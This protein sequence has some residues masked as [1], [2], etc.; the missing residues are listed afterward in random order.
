MP[1]SH[2]YRRRILDDELDVLMNGLPA[3]ALEGAKAVGKTATASERATTVHQLDDPDQRALA[4]ADPGRLLADPPPVLIDEW[5]FVPP[6]WDRVR[7]AVDADRTPGRFLLTGSSSP[8][9][10]GTHSGAARIVSLRL[11]PLALAERLD[12]PPSVSVT[13]LLRGERPAIAGQSGLTLEDY[14]DQILRSGFPG[15]RGMPERAVR[16]Q[17]DAY[18]GRIVDRDF[19]ELGHVVR[20]PT[21][22]R[23][24]MAA[25]AA[26]TATSTSFEKIRAAA[27][28]GE[29]EKPAKTTSHAYRDV[30]ERLFILDELPGWQH[31]R[32]YIRQL[33]LP[34]KHHLADPALAARLLGANRDRLLRGESPGPSIPRDG[35]LLGALFESLV[36]LSVRVYAQ[37]ADASVGHL[38]TKGGRHEVDLIVERDD[39]KVV[40]I[41]VK[42]GATP[43]NAETKHLAWL[44]Q[45]LGDDLL[46][47]V[48]VTTGRDAYRREDGIAVVPAALLG[49]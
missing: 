26:A 21:R 47:A 24:W 41:E 33:A 42:L 25:Y 48:V 14:A 18:L 29:E 32:N 7:R 8:V 9:E 5:Q 49:P 19:P 43:R 12:E 1:S 36:T 39:G 28:G 17:L 15:L 2:T 31:S 38:R 6:V 23:R 22:L 20:N 11:R 46:D 44:K 10:R 16:A 37:V 4:E 40:A 3:I 27:T 45:E 30:L 34:P 13:E 35:T